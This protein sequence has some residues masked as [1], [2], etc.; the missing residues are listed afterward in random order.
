MD[1]TK[2]KI[3]MVQLLLVKMACKTLFFLDYYVIHRE[4]GVQFN[5]TKTSLST[6]IFHTHCTLHLGWLT[7][8]LAWYNWKITDLYS[9]CVVVTIELL[10]KVYIKPFI[11]YCLF[12][13]IIIGYVYYFSIPKINHAAVVK[14]SREI[15]HS[16]LDP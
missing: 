15:C 12:A 11:L 9:N 6:L 16:L 5:N 8:W 13:Y 1:I 10:P 4:N 2:K 7:G 14:M 3:I